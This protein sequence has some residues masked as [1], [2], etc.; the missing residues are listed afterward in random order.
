[1]RQRLFGGQIRTSTVILL[2][3]FVLTLV[4]YLLVRPD[5][6]KA[7]WSGQPAPPN[8]CTITTATPPPGGNHAAAQPAGAHH[9]ADRHTGGA[10]VADG[11]AHHRG[12]DRRRDHHGTGSG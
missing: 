10:P 2:F 5:P 12:S 1:M 3:V 4:A 7:Q 11:T 9:G 8:P 6:T